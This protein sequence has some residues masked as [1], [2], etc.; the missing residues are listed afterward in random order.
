MRRLSANKVILLAIF[1][2][3]AVMANAADW[4]QWR[5]LQRDGVTSETIATNWPA[6]GPHQLWSTNVGVGHAPV[7]IAGTRAITLGHTGQNDRV[8][9]FHATDGRV[10]W[11]FD[12][13][14][15]ARCPGEY[16]NG[17]FD[18]PHAA[19]TISGTN[20]FTF[21]R[22]GKIFCFDL[23]TGAQRWTRDLCADLKAKMPE[24]GFASAPLV[25][26]G[27]VFVNVGRN[28]TALDA[29]TGATRWQSGTDMAGYAALALDE[30]DAAQR[31]LLVFG[32]KALYSV[33]PADGQTNWSL[34]W[35][36]QWGD[37]TVDP[38]VIG[39]GIFITTAYGRGCAWLDARTGAVR[40]QNKNLSA[41]C[42]PPVLRDGSLFG[43]DGYINYA[44]GQALVCL[45]PQTGAIK[46]RKDKLAGQMILA[47]DRLVLALT[48]GELVLARAT[49]EAYSE[50][51]CARLFSAEQCPVPPV[52]A[53]GR[54]YC[55]NGAGH[56][57]CLDV[58]PV[59]F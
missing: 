9:C 14:A 29:A 8:W 25:R 13:P 30:A 17:A 36:T 54:L 42:S 5:G 26:D 21:S 37:N 56:L 23:A 31:R 35:P 12:Y 15:I 28:G 6:G 46:W 48:T 47:G 2:F 16:G 27:V 33:N 1:A 58:A 19:P 34:A 55:R 57:I 22:D 39:D 40:W 20:V 38:M 51:V 49:P 50:I 52:L 3:S 10:L 53:N 45:N 44:P 43:F 7:S 4:P 41:Q 59:V 32:A 18:G 24:C 11:Q